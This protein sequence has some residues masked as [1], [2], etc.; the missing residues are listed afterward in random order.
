MNT[1]R[2]AQAEALCAAVRA[3][4][5]AAALTR[6]GATLDAT[7]VAHGLVP[8]IVVVSAPKLTFDGAF[9]DVQAEYELH[10]IAGP[11]DD[12]L[13]AWGYIDVIIQALVDADINLRSG[14]P[15]AFE[16]QYGDA[17]PC[18]TLTLNDLD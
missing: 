14:E 17:V 7:E 11:V 6:V 4:L 9:G 12:Y 3:A 8:G 15:G 1:P 10:V 5:D 13:Q 16:L 18:Y 2:I